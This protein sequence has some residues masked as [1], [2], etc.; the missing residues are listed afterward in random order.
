[1][2]IISFSY[3]LS[4]CEQYLQNNGWEKVTHGKWKAPRH[5]GSEAGNIFFQYRAMIT[6]YS[7]D[8]EQLRP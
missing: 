2:D 6:Q 5:L 8:S 7:Y 4:A 1:M 3:F